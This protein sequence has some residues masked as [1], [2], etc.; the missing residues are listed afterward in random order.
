VQDSER[1]ANAG[2]SRQPQPGVAAEALFKRA[3][4][5]WPNRRLAGVTSAQLPL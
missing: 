5:T 1:K 4:I 2:P 3:L